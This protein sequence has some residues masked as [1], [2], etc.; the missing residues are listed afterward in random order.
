MC[1][2]A[3]QI[4][5]HPDRMADEAVVRHLGSGL[6]HR[7]PDGDGFYTSPSRRLA[8]GMRRLAVIDLVSGDQPIFNED[9]TVACVLNGREG[10]APTTAAK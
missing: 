10:P 9:N 4:A 8:L 2:S 5:L 6:V 7:S 1:G 3:G